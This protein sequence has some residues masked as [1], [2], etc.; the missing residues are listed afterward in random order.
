MHRI[1]GLVLALVAPTLACGGAGAPLAVP[2]AVAEPARPAASPA[3]ASEPPAP[4]EPAFT[5]ATVAWT[6]AAARPVRMPRAIGGVAVGIVS[7]PERGLALVGIDAANGARRWQQPITPGYAPPGVAVDWHKV[8]KDKLAYLR[9]VYA[10]K[11]V[12]HLVVADAATGRDL[13]VSPP[14]WFRS[15]IVECTSEQNLCATATI[16]EN[17]P[18]AL[19]YR[20]DVDTGRFAAEAAEDVAD[21]SDRA[22]LIGERG[23]YDL[24]DRPA[25]TLALVRDGRV[26]WR[27][28]LADAFPAGF[29]TDRG[30]AWSLV[31]DQHIYVGSTYG[32]MGRYGD[33][34]VIH[35]LGAE[36]ATAG[37]AELDGKV[38][39][40]DV[41]SNLQCDLGRDTGEH[42]VR[43]RIRG[44]SVRP[45]RS[46]GAT[47]YEGLQIGVEGFDVQTG[48]TT[49]SLSL[50]PSKDLHDAGS[51]P[52]I[53]GATRTL[54]EA[55]DGPVILDYAS[56]KIEKPAPGATFFCRTR[57]AYELAAP[58]PSRRGTPVTKRIGGDLMFV[59]DARRQPATV[60]P[61][62]DVI[63][64]AGAR[65]GDHVVVATTDGFVGYL[66]GR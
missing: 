12:A 30:W 33:H 50:G 40:K 1:I 46:G 42:P 47:S 2:P 62:P 37:I 3:A 5:R 7:T 25:N 28:P 21:V 34:K 29:S 18:P 45:Q 52:P 32:D 4:A 24:G 44:S 22:R 41:G 63:L 49:W 6:D 26:K 48:R 8:G 56:G 14:L 20:L 60:L 53:A 43:C 16:D 38:L 10:D 54:V 55:D 57:A 17:T 64:G 11:L 36:T 9:P 15:D 23:L 51:P 58:L 19:P 13:I 65:V 59:C 31:T 61:A 35:D 66:L 27:L 39:W